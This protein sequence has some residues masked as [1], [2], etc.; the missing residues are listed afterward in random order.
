MSE[1]HTTSDSSSELP[2]LVHRTIRR[3][4]RRHTPVGV[5]RAVR[6]LD[7]SLPTSQAEDTGRILRLGSPESTLSAS[8]GPKDEDPF[9][10]TPDQPQP[11]RDSGSIII[12]AEHAASPQRNE[13]PLVKALKNTI[14]RQKQ[15][16]R[17]KINALERARD[18]LSRTRQQYTEMEM[19]L[20]QK[21][22]TI[23]ALRKSENQYRNWWLNEI[24]FTK[25]LLNK[26]PEPNRD[27]ELARASQARYPW[28]LLV[29]ASALGNIILTRSEQLH[30]VG[31][32]F[33]FNSDPPEVLQWNSKLHNLRMKLRINISAIQSPLM[34]SGRKLRS[35]TATYDCGFKPQPRVAP[36]HTLPA[37]ARQIE[38]NFH[39][40]QSVFGVSRIGESLIV[41]YAPPA[42]IIA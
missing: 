23:A 8:S 5:S 37:D 19:D 15:Q 7:G 18:E 1:A 16:L 35:F 9:A 41:G 39:H 29:G 3:S 33:F 42:E 21:E 38:V 10:L 11:E 20:D 12:E 40:R 14:E 28:P 26:S 30:P 2:T 17:S 32:T 36:V 31:V 24:Q 22:E 6:T 27:M 34:V 25:L 4:S 13:G